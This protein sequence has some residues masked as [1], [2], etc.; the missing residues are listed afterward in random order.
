MLIFDTNYKIMKKN[1]LFVASLFLGT[2]TF[3]QF[4]QSNAPADGDGLTLY[5]IDSLA[6]AY[7]NET[8]ASATWDYSAVK[9]YVNEDRNVTAIDATVTPNA[10]DFPNATISIDI[11]E[12]IQ[13]FSHPASNERNS[14][15]FVFTE[16]NAGE[17]I[18]KF[19]T[20]EA[21]TYTYPMDENSPLIVDS[22][23]GNLDYALGTAALL[24]EIQ[25]EVDGKGTL[26]L[27]NNVV[28]NNVLRYKTTENM[29]ATLMILGDVEITRVQYEYYDHTQSD[30]PIFI[31]TTID[32]QTTSGANL[33]EAT[34]VLSHEEPS[35]F[36]AVTENELAKTSIYPNPASDE[37]TIEL[38]TK[39]ES[40]NIVITDM[41]GRE[42][43]ST[44]MNNAMK[45]VDVSTLNKGAYIMKIA[46]QNTSITKNIVIK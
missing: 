22:I 16:P 12:F 37:L 1:L 23:K 38:P 39:V 36:L 35:E 2:A 5:V 10:S 30:L 18:A 4:T 19:D 45:T 9:G 26:M 14:Y 40:A 42:V 21:L 25:A 34:L 24:G 44:S 7:E 28:Y 3:A 11:E 27:A 13:T 29:E 41:Q 15:G 17:V 31:H 43:L 6:P 20:D 8:G 33:S 46:S 32:V